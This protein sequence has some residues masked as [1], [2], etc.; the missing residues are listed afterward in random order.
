MGKLIERIIEPE[1]IQGAWKKA[2]NSFQVGDIWFDEM[3]LASFEANLY[4]E[5]ENIKNDIISRSYVL[6]KIKP[7]P[8]P[9]GIDKENG[10]PRV[11]QTF[12]VRV[13]DQVTWIA[14]IN[15]I[16]DSLDYQMPWWSYGH[17]LF[18]PVWKDKNNQWSIGRY[19]HSIGRLYRKWNQSWPLFRRNVSITAKVMCNFKKTIEETELD[20]AEKKVFENNEFLI[21]NFK[22]QYLLE[23][24][25]GTRSASILYWATIDFSKFYPSVKRSAIL[26]NIF[27][28]TDGAN[29]DEDFRLFM[30]RLMDFHVDYSEW[31]TNEL[32]YINLG[33]KKFD[34]LPTGLFVAG[35]LANV[36]LLGVDSYVSKEL[37]KNREVAHFRFVDDH[38]ILAY[39]FEKLIE[40]IKKYKSFLQDS[41]IGVTFNFDKIEPK[42]LST[43]IKLDGLKEVEIDERERQVDIAK[44]ASTLDPLFPAPLM[45]Q[46]L[47]KVSAISNR[48][49]EF[50]SNN[51]EEQLISD[52]EHLLL[53]DFPDHELRKD[54]RVSF[55]ASILSRLVTN[56]SDNYTDIYECQKKIHHKLKSY[57][58]LFERS[59]GQFISSKLHDLIFIEPID[60]DG[61][62]FKWAIEID[63]GKLEKKEL[64]ESIKEEKKK[65]IF[66]RNN[67]KKQNVSQKNRVYGLLIKAISENPEK[68]RIWS[69]VIDYCRKVGYCHPKKTYN[70]ITQ[71]LTEDRIHILS[72]NF[73]RTLFINVLADRVM[74]SVFTL[75]N[76]T[77]S[78]KKDYNAVIAFLE[79]V[80]SSNFLDDIF[81]DERC[82][83]RLYYTKTYDYYR[84]VLGSAMFILRDFKLEFLKNFGF[85]IQRYKLINWT[86]DPQQWINNTYLH[87]INIWLYWLLWKTHDKSCSK[88]LDFWLKLQLFIDYGSL[89][90]KPL[91][92]PFPNIEYLPKRDNVFLSYILNG[93]FNEGWIFELFKNGKEKIGNNIKNK[94]K[95]KY[96]NLFNNI[97]NSTP[98]NINL[99]EFIHWQD[100][101]LCRHFENGIDSFNHFFDPRFSE[102]TALELVKQVIEKIDISGEDFFQNKAKNKLHPANFFIP[103]DLIQDGSLD[104]LS[105]GDWKGKISGR[106]E[107]Q[108]PDF[109]ISDERYTTKALR[110]SSDGGNETANV[111]ALGLILLQLITHNTDFPWVWNSTDKSLI[112]EGLIYTKIQNTALSSYTLLIL[113][114]CFSSKNR[115]SFYNAEMFKSFDNIKG[116]TASDPPEINDTYTLR[117]YIAVSQ[118]IIEKY[119]LSM[120]DNIPRQLIPISLLQ[121]SKDNNPLEDFN[122]T[123]NDLSS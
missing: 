75:L 36:A 61:Y 9:K 35:F 121:L 70:K 92:L 7:L 52:L 56:T 83:T 54:T 60:V 97:F 37:I 105:W 114:S 28:Y 84:F 90:C 33:N 57:H 42:Q 32:D 26:K 49:F 91:I 12:E 66:L 53:T 13:R 108:T 10:N 62:F 69:R 65:E 117:R 47:S 73:L 44:K 17:R 115:E 88:P 34:G 24:Y 123:E 2:K 21:E 16:G 58:K 72:G 67:L 112:W 48:D 4:E 109:Q 82:C 86:E 64:L 39:D 23:G 89:T 120:E 78:S 100:D 116:D 96:P 11:R 76:K 118:K 107:V 25:W 77:N 71:F 94:L 80:F 85:I 106:L 55:A 31:S 81:K 6:G 99:W 98:T 45:T 5:L 41:D 79:S 1:N 68:V 74:Q 103:R 110:R 43:I 63:D 40:W 19:R 8:Y 122:I 113:Q 38:V 46:T 87:D 50:L 18:V 51:E 27:L 119:Q 111:Y 59:D 15:I 29:E 102:W 20:E 93:G 14:V 22:S 95:E 30:E 104:I 3:E 101:N